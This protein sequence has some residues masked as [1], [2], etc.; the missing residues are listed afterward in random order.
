M[1]EAAA[2]DLNAG[3]SGSFASF[4]RPELLRDFRILRVH[5]TAEV[6]RNK[7]IFVAE[8]TIEGADDWIRPG[9][10]GIAAIRIGRRPIWWV[11]SHRIIDFLR[12]HVWL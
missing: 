12:L 7:N 9:M 5:P 10:E 4:A 1:P 11:S 8:A 3:L 6:R 2:E